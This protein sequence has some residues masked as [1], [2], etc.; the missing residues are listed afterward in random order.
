MK[1]S[2]LIFGSAGV[3]VGAIGAGAEAAGAVAAGPSLSFRGL[4]GWA[5]P[6]IIVGD[7]PDWTGR[8]I[9]VGLK[10]KKKQLLVLKMIQK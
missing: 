7:M 8:T 9:P 4:L 2:F 3:A 5:E 1:R 6:P 10:N